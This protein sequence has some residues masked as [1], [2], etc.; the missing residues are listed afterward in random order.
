[1]IES[2]EASED[3]EDSDSDDGDIEAQIKRELEGLKPAKAK[4]RPVQ[5]MQLDM[6]CGM[7]SCPRIA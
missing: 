6:P 1:M 5:G 3:K 4:T 7:V 2:T